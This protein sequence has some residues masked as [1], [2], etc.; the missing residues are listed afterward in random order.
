MYM[1]CR[2]IRIYACMYS[3]VCVCMCVYVCVCVCMCMCMCTCKCI[4]IC[5]LIGICRCRCRRRRRC[6][7]KCNC[8]Y[9][10]EYVY[11]MHT[12]MYMNMY[13]SHMPGF[14]CSCRINRLVAGC[15]LRRP[16]FGLRLAIV[17]IAACCL[18]LLLKHWFF[19]GFPSSVLGPAP[20]GHAE[21]RTTAVP[22][23]GPCPT[24]KKP[25]PTPKPQARKVV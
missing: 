23:E 8:I 11:V 18:H 25:K 20:F 21:F 12:Y 10:H 22:R 2:C 3:C 1:Y 19:A 14:C 15:F 9:V 24:P 5:M 16:L 17:D 7:C 6:Q 13:T 4:F